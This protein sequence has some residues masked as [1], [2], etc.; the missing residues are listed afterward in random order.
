MEKNNG[1]MHT[2]DDIIYHQH[3]YYVE[4]VYWGCKK[5]KLEG[6]NML[7]NKSNN[8]TPLSE[9]MPILLYSRAMHNIFLRSMHKFFNSLGKLDQQVIPKEKVHKLY[10]KHCRKPKKF[11]N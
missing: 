6:G 7:S 5:I 2:C 4:R 10:L 9:P 8:F 1:T 11:K 3:T